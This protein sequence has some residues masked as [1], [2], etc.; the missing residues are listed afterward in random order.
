MENDGE[1]NVNLS[2]GDY[3]ENIGRD[4]DDQFRITL[5]EKAQIP[6]HYLYVEA[7][8]IENS[9]PWGDYINSLSH[10]HLI[11]Y[12]VKNDLDSDIVWRC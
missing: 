9:F 8:E 7:V 11:F 1:L 3:L 10:R 2:T 12:R 6:F 5:E 4:P